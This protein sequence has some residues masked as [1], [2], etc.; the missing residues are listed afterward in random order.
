MDKIIP[1]LGIDFNAIRVPTRN[2]TRMCMD[3][4]AVIYDYI[5]RESRLARIFIIP[6]I[7]GIE[8]NVAVLTKQYFVEKTPTDIELPETGYARDEKK[9]W[10]KIS[11]ADSLVEY[12]E[13]YWRRSNCANCSAGGR[14][15]RRNARHLVLVS[16]YDEK[17]RVQGLF[18][19]MPSM[20]S[21]PCPTSGQRLCAE[22]AFW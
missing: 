3:D 13:K 16:V 5:K 8:N 7:S 14:L 2:Y 19:R 1:S 9:R 18:F 10:D 6:R 20:Y 12:S 22:N 17:I 11:G 15:G 21:R 4:N